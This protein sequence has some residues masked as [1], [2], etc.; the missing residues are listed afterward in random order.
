MFLRSDFIGLNVL[1]IRIIEDEPEFIHL[2]N[3]YK[4]AKLFNYRLFELYTENNKF[5]Y[6]AIR[7]LDVNTHFGNFIKQQNIIEAYYDG[8][9]ENCVIIDDIFFNQ[10]YK[11][12]NSGSKATILQLCLF[13]DDQYILDKCKSK[14]GFYMVAKISIN[15]VN[16]CIILPE[17]NITD[18]RID[19]MFIIK[20]F[21][22]Y[23]PNICLEIDEDG[24]NDRDRQSELSR[25]NFTKTFGYKIIRVSNSKF[26]DKYRHYY[27]KCPFM[28][29]NINGMS[30]SQ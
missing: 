25:E 21:D 18:I 9:G 6:Y 28:S 5:A 29:K 8:Y 19:N 2:K 13:P 10:L 24:H 26:I 22:S 3:L 14:V 11:L 20:S 4:H 15:L 7:L 23:I 17:H 12:K 16:K 1:E 30:L 27:Y